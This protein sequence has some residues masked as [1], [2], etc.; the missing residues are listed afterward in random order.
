MEISET[1]NLLLNLACGLLPEN[2]SKN[3]ID[4]LKSRFGE[5]WFDVLGYRETEYKKPLS[6]KKE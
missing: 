3:E 6:D 4:L 5:N 2:L 1:D